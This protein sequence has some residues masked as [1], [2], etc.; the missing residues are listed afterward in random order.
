MR[1]ARYLPCVGDVE[2]PMRIRKIMAQDVLCNSLFPKR[3]PGL[4]LNRTS[5][6]CNNVSRT[7]FVCYF[8]YFFSV[9]Y[10]NA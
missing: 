3:M 2:K 7:L 10:H 8:V 9:L 1:R 4:S 5:N 6:S